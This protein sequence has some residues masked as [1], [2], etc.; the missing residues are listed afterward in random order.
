[1]RGKPGPSTAAWTAE[2]RRA[3][4][5]DRR[6]HRRAAAVMD[7]TAPANRTARVGAQ[8]VG[9][10]PTPI[11]CSAVLLHRGVP[12]NDRRDSSRSAVGPSR[13]AKPGDV[14]SAPGNIGSDAARPTWA[15]SCHHPAESSPSALWRRSRESGREAAG[16]T[17]QL[18]TLA[19]HPHRLLHGLRRW[20]SLSAA[21]AQKS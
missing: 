5:P 2:R 21:A 7:G 9:C 8:P 11:P 6:R 12:R 18:S 14:M 20:S 19:R 1:M 3:E 13:P 4:C 15:R 10:R 17:Q 16:H